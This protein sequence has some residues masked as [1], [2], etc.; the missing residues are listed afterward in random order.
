MDVL[1]HADLRIPDAYVSGESFHAPPLQWTDWRTRIACRCCRSLPKWLCLDIAGKTPLLTSA[2]EY[3]LRRFPRT[4]NDLYDSTSIGLEA[5]P[6]TRLIIH[7]ADSL[8][9]TKSLI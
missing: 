7:S 8:I 4:C 5:F 9:A 6:H 1:R 2:F 3:C